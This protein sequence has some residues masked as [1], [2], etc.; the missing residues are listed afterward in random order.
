MRYRI[1]DWRQ[2][3]QVLLV[4]VEKTI[5]RTFPA[6]SKPKMRTLVSERRKRRVQR[7]EKVTEELVSAC[8]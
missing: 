4:C 7:E 6:L 8:A 3:R 5:R 2:T 1:V